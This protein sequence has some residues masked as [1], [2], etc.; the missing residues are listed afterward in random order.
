VDPDA[1][2]LAPLIQQLLL[3]QAKPLENLWEKA[4]WRALRLRDAL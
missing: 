4:R 2:L 3:G 1:T